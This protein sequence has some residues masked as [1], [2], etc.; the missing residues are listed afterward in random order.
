MPEH[1]PS[2]LV[3][4]LP[5]IDRSKGVLEGE[6]NVTL[7][8][9]LAAL[10]PGLIV[11]IDLSGNPFGTKFGD[12]VP[13]LRRARDH[14][15]RLALHCG[16]FD[17]EQEV[18]EMFD[19]GV[20]RI[21]HGTFITGTLEIDSKITKDSSLLTR[22]LLAGGNLNFAARYR[23]PFECC[24]TSN[25]KCKTVPSYEDHHFG[26]LINFDYTSICTYICERFYLLAQ[27]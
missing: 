27:V 14:G 1:Q 25:V 21:G 17:D 15:F 24:L 22:P 6:E 7:A 3:K 11:G 19:L 8:I 2:I 13:S 18:K 10:Y 4:L 5:S 16:E 9:E 20:D 12:F 23:I 26:K